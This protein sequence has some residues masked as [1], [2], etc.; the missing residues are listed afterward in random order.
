MRCFFVLLSVILCFASTVHA[1]TIEGK[2]LDI[3]KSPV[4]F[5]NV[6][7]TDS[8]SAFLAGCVTD[9]RGCFRFVKEKNA[10]LLKV[11]FIGYKDRWLPLEDSRKDLGDIILE[12]NAVNLEEVTIHADLPKVYLKGDAQVTDVENSVL[13]DV[14]SGNEVLK[15]IPGMVM[16]DGSLEVFGKGTSEAMYVNMPK[17]GLAIAT[18]HIPV[19][20]ETNTARKRMNES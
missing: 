8:D 20:P 3:Q 10:V 5:V 15:R 18:E 6:I 17:S 2:V 14:G 19:S 1:Q 12:Q 7:Q 16:K 11:S 9:E 13:K 4:M